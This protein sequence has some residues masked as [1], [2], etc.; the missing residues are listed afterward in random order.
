MGA[1]PGAQGILQILDPPPIRSHLRG[2]I[3]Q[4]LGAHSGPFAT[5]PATL[6][7]GPGF[8]LGG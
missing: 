6:G 7:F 2:Q 8:G 4:A 1:I 5:Q 3:V